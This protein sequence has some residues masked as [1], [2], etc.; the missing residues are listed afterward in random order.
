MFPM[1]KTYLMKRKG[2]YNWRIRLQYPGE[3][4]FEK[5]LGTRDEK[6]AEIIAL[7]DHGDKIAEHK[8]RLLAARPRIEAAWRHEYKPGLHV[9][10][11]GRRIFATDRELHYLDSEGVTIRTVPNGEPEHRVINLERRLGIPYAPIEITDKARP[12]LAAKNGDDLL[13][14]TYLKHAKVTGYY[15]RE[16]RAV[17]ALYKQLTNNK[18]L[19]DATRDDGRKVV[20]HLRNRR[21]RARP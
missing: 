9:A 4:V 5:S 6:L 19:K 1:S 11:D 10:P 14:E 21:S 15:E 17:W 8:A 3:P 2:S 20:A 12:A 16:A 18:P 7:R 13:L